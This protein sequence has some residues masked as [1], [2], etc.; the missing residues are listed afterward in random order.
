MR[1]V[2]FDDLV[3]RE[4]QRYRLA[5]LDLRFYENADD[6]L[7]IIENETPDLV[8]MDFSMEALRTGVEAVTL[9]RQDPRFATL[10]IVAISSD[11]Q[12]NERLLQAGAT[13][14]VPKSHLR[15]YLNRFSPLGPPR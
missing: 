13:D 4:Q 2:I 15:G 10:P 1:I 14:A 3:Y 6:V 5:G 12:A 11:R 8:C 9:V 7:S